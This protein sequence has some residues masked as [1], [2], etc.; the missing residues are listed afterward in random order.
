M[1]ARQVVLQ[2]DEVA[3]L[4][5]FV[6]RERLSHPGET[7]DVLVPHHQRAIA[8]RQSV[9]RHVGPAHARHFH[10]HQGGIVGKRRQIQLA[11][12]CG[13]GADLHGGQQFFR[14][15]HTSS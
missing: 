10:F 12:L 7:T 9:L 6:R 14:Q 5:A 8:Q 15:S 1:A 3:F 4:Q 2:E 13:R 11:Q